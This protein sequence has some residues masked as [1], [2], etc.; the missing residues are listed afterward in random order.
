MTPRDKQICNLL[1]QGADNA[2]IA[3]TLGMK[4]RTVKAHFS[5][6]FLQYRI[7][8][9][10]KRVKLAVLLY[11]ASRLANSKSQDSSATDSKTRTLPTP[12]ESLSTSPRTT[13]VTFLTGLDSGTVSS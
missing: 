5:R 11:R 3:S 8:D 12:S 4:P 6:L 9:G 13:S 7:Q 1:L 10:H 2:D